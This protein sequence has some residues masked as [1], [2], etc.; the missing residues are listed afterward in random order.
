MTPGRSFGSSRP[1]WPAAPAWTR[2][3]PRW[4]ASEFTPPV[5]TRLGYLHRISTLTAFGLAVEI[6]DWGRLS[7]RWNGSQVVV[8]VRLDA[9]G[10]RNAMSPRYE[11]KPNYC[12]LTCG[13]GRHSR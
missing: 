1:L 6:G 7:G 12:L 4:P 10:G 5:V 3:S 13:M 2:R 8:G 9:G 11:R